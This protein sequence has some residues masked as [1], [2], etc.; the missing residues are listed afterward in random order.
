MKKLNKNWITEKHIDLE[1]K[2]Y[3][4]LAYLNEVNNNFDHNIL[5]PYYA[6]L[7]E[8]HEQL[9]FLQENTQNLFESFPDRAKGIDLQNFNIIYEKAIENDRLMQEIQEI[10]NYS[11]PQIEHCLNEG[12]KIYD[13]IEEHLRIDPIGILPLHP[14]EGYLLL[15][16]GSNKQTRVYEYQITLFDKPDV[17]YKHVHTQYVRS[18][19]KNFINTLESIKT[20]LIRGNKKLPNPATYAVETEMTLPFNETFLPIAKRVLVKYVTD[21]NK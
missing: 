7:K 11:I 13:F 14:G 6:E 18:Y 1:Y 2:R 21:I 4:L 15:R 8:H 20:D 10:I 9:I 17:K 3:L 19:R 5:Y 16:N 12:R